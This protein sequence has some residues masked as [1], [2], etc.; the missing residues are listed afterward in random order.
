[1][2]PSSQVVTGRWAE[3]LESAHA[4]A[5]IEVVGCL[6]S[7]SLVHTD[8]RNALGRRCMDVQDMREK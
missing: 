7:L 8:V 2:C 6:G 5:A 1:V 4:E 3:A